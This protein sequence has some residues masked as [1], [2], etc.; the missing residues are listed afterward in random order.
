[1]RAALLLAAALLAPTAA[2]GQEPA[3]PGG[4]A[5]ALAD[6]IPTP[7][8]RLGGI[9][10]TVARGALPA[11][12]VPF[13]ITMLE[14]ADRHVATPAV[15]L[16]ELLRR[17]P[18]VVVGNRHN[19]A[20]DTR[21]V[22][23]GF[24]ARSAFGV[25]GVRI[26]L[27]GIPLTL[28]DGQA[29]LTN[30]DP[31]SIGRVEVIRG[32]AA[33]LYGNAAGGVIALS[34]TEPPPDG[35]LEVRAAAG[36]YGTGDPGNLVRL[37]GN[38]GGTG[39]R[40]SWFVGLSHLAT[41][42]FRDYSSARRTGLNARYRRVVGERSA[43]TAILNVAVVP[44]AQNPGALPLDS[45]EQRPRMAWP[46]NV[47][48]GS[49]KEVSQAQ[50]G[51]A[52]SHDL[53]PALV[54]A[55]AY[56]LGRSMD[57]P[58]PFG[59]YIRLARSGGGARVVMRAADDRPTSW[60]AGFEAQMQ[61]D[62]RV[63]R[64]NIAGAMGGATYQ[65]RVDRVA[66]LAP[67]AFA[68]V[69]VHPRL[70]VRVGGRYDAV[71]FDSENR[72]G[73][74]AA[75]RSAR[76]VLDAWSG[77]TGALFQ[78]GT[79]VAA[80]GSLSTWFQTP[81]TTELI[82]VPPQPGEECCQTGFNP[83][84]EPQDGWGWEAGLRG[85]T[86]P[87]AW[88]VTGFDLSV[89]N[90]ILPF[91]V[92]GVDGRDFYRNAGRSVHR[93]VEVGGNA[94]LGRGWGIGVAYAYSGFRFDEQGD[95]ALAGNRLPGIP[96]HRLDAWLSRT[97]GVVTMELEL[98]WVDRAP[99]NDANTAFAPAYA[100]ADVR[101]ARQMAVAG[102]MLEPFVAVTNVLDVRYSA[103]VVINAFGGRYHEPGPGRALLLG[104]RARFR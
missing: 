74:A 82:N 9:E 26:L 48:T 11:D 32:P 14:S 59:R 98:E 22:V 89:R 20:M 5:T 93:G 72:L 66:S 39:V 31:G 53:G 58:L 45:A 46:Q 80:F 42:G 29:A 102:A 54:E 90:E 70:A 1:M 75:D 67:F 21:V 35:M 76:R 81:T 62:D 25:R 52:F 69:D 30:V 84:L 83:D 103:S 99:V 97:A 86:G 28:P 91:Q 38:A 17:V 24:G 49:S 65:D 34:T 44:L 41:D 101:A 6:T 104:L 19:L 47:S 36:T 85:R 3:E 18:G 87:V 33:A 61:S 15:D 8:Y 78:L 56:G 7:V 79:G 77:S 63:E 4:A 88:E 100:I 37:Q 68:Q 73:S 60:T 43:V 13:A 64:D 57:N 10:A 95:D 92:E 94:G 96:P 50:G 12:R 16:Q 27:D 51:A 71:V 23:R 2:V 55:A 40:D